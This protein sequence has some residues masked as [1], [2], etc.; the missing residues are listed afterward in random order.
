MATMTITQRRGMAYLLA[1]RPLRLRIASK[2]LIRADRLCFGADHSWRRRQLN[3][4]CGAGWLTPLWD[5]LER[6][7]WKFVDD[8]M[9]RYERGEVSF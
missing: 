9:E 8:W 2:A 6:R 4:T 3:G 7:E 5:L 1:K